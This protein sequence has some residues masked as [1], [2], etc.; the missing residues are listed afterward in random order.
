MAGYNTILRELIDKAGEDKILFYDDIFEFYDE[1]EP[2]FTKI[3]K[4]LEKAKIEVYQDEE[5]YD[6]V[7]LEQLAHVD[8]IVAGGK[9]PDEFDLSSLEVEEIEEGVLHNIMSDHTAIVDDPVKMYL[10]DIGQIPLLTGDEE[11][12]LAKKISV[13]REARLQLE[14]MKEEGILTPDDER[15]LNH[16]IEMADIAKHKLVEANYRLVVHMAKKFDKGSVQFM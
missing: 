15:Q 7:I 12:E 16:V 9:E 1:D 13:G 4:D 3:L 5:E 6:A 11:V 14:Y 2:D 10:K 8:E